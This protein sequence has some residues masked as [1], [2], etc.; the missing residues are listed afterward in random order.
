MP[1]YIALRKKGKFSNPSPSRVQFLLEVDYPSIKGDL[2]LANHASLKIYYEEFLFAV[3]DTWHKEC[4]LEDI[5]G[6][7]NF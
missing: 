1:Q 7:G 4:K 5:P 6:A 2:G 3:R